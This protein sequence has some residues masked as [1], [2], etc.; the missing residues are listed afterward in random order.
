MIFHPNFRLFLIATIVFHS[1]YFIP[2]VCAEGAPKL[3]DSMEAFD[4]AYKAFRREKDAA[5]ALPLVRDAQKAC[6][7]SITVL[8]PMI[9][10]M[11]DGVAKDQAAASY[12]N[13]MAEVYLM[14][15]KL[16]LAYLKGDMETVEALIGELR[17]S[18]RTGH[19]KFM[20][21]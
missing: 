6:V 11:A 2:A 4:R 14:L 18:R 20:E 16:E 8:P 1:S 19:E 10:K 9:E 7:Q 3:I 5:K 13:M 15:T 17:A 12:R 21:E